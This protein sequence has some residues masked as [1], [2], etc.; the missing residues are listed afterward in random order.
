MIAKTS[1]ADFDPGQPWTGYVPPEQVCANPDQP[2]KVFAEPELQALG[3]SM[4]ISQEQPCTVVPAMLKGFPSVRWMLVDGE[5]RWRAATAEGL[6]LLW[7][8]YK[9]GVTAENIHRCSL[10]ANF[11]RAGHTKME[12]CNAFA[13]ELSLG[14]TTLE[15]AT[16]IGKSEAS[17]LQ[18]LALQKLHPELQAK[19]DGPKGDRLPFATGVLLSKLPPE[20]Q[21][22][23]WAANKD[24]PA[25]AQTHAIRTTAVKTAGYSDATNAQRITGMVSKALQTIQLLNGLGEIMMRSLTPN[26]AAKIKNMLT[27]MRGQAKQF[28]QRLEARIDGEET[29]DAGGAQ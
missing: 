4:R 17:V 7:V 27:E 5:R 14:A 29:P 19:L 24:K 15:I 25:M 16:S 26:R 9:P 10:T 6:P 11:C 12:T 22:K 2:R 23:A 28:E 3:M 13:H 1:R 21:L 18:Y 20:Q 8:T